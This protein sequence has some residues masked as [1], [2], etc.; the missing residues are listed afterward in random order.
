MCEFIQNYPES[1]WNT[2]DDHLL[3]TFNLLI[4]GRLM[5]KNT[6]WQKNALELDVTDITLKMLA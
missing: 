1:Y 5:V 3:N 2:A 4:C 6:E